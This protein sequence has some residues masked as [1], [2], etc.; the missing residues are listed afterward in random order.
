MA[1]WLTLLALIPLLALVTRDR[2]LTY[3]SYGNSSNPHTAQATAQY[4]P[5]KQISPQ[6]NSSGNWQSTLHNSS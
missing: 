6:Q 5:G 3:V 1:D 2:V 4:V